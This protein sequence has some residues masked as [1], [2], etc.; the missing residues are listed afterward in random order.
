[1]LINGKPVEKED[2]KV[3]KVLLLNASYEPLNLCSWKRAL[4]LLLKGKAEEVENTYNLIDDK[5]TLPSVIRLR[6]Y[7]VVPYKELP[8]NRKNV[9]HRDN[10]TCQY[11]GKTNCTLTIDHVIPK[12]RG[13]KNTWENVVAACPRC[14][15]VKADKTPAEAGMK[16][17]TIPVKPKDY[18]K[19]EVS[20]DSSDAFD[21][22][23]SYLLNY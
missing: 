9:F 18:M 5:K 8:F 16:L 22:W 6:Y 21:E 13:G 4:I 12:S 14:N 3:R 19:F 20:K 10:Y 7:V 1:M 2:R 11:C 23:Q 17:K 15:F